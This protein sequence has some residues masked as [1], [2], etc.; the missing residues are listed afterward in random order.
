MPVSRRPKRTRAA[1]EVR[2]EEAKVAEIAVDEASVESKSTVQKRKRVRQHATK[3]EFVKFHPVPRYALDLPVPARKTIVG[4]VFV[5][6]QGDCAQL[7]LGPDILEAEKP[8]RIQSLTGVVDITCGGLHTLALTE[9]GKVYSWGCNDHRALGRDG[10]EHEPGLVQG[11]ENVSIVKIAAGDNISCALS[12][13]GKLYVWG[14]F[15]NET[16]VFGFFPGIEIQPIAVLFFPLGHM[17]IVDVA[18]GTDH[19]LALNSYGEVYTWGVGGQGQLGRRTVPRREMIT[20]LVPDR[21]DL[22]RITKIGTGAY[23]SFAIDVDGDAYVWGLNNYGQCAVDGPSVMPI[24]PR[25]LALPAG[26]RIVD[27][28]GGEHHSIALTDK[29]QVYV[30][31]RTD[32]HQLG[33]GYTRVDT[34][35]NPITTEKQTENGTGDSTSE[36]SINGSHPPTDQSQRTETRSFIR[37][38]QLNPHVS[39]V[40]LISSFNHSS[41]AV[42]GDGICFSWGFGEYFQLGNREDHDEPTPFRIPTGEGTKILVAGCGGQHTVLLALRNQ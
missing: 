11:L 32:S 17:T 34:S 21:L 15:R 8:K 36:T 5:I 3:P 18:C 13:D 29:G 14:T 28:T 33:L 9:D 37:T 24:E 2:P 12:D 16:G 6:G 23:H 1:V 39:K 35:G 31:G 27:I 26:T 22:K 38:P 30:W 19:V 40:N 4:E 41:T 7:G 42:D 10:S 20:S 25:I